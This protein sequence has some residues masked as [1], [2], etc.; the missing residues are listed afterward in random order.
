MTDVKHVLHPAPG[1]AVQSTI[2]CDNTQDAD[3]GIYERSIPCQDPMSALQNRQ[4]QERASTGARLKRVA[5]R[6]CITA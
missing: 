3:A 5:E 1:K 6:G 4:Y 2:Y